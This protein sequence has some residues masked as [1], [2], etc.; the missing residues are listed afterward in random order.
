MGLRSSRRGGDVGRSRQIEVEVGRWLLGARL[1]D[2]R[3]QPAEMRGLEHREAAA[4]V[5]RGEA[6]VVDRGADEGAK[7]STLLRADLGEGD[8]LVDD[9]GQLEAGLREVSWGRIRRSMSAT[10]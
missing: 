2:L 5:L 3:H 8:D 9:P 4:A 1:A 10:C 6:E 7:R